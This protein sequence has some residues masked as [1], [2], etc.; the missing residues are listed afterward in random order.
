MTHNLL[1]DP[2]ISVSAGGGNQKLSLPGLLG[3]MARLEVTGFPAMRPHQGAAWHMFLVQLGALALWNEDQRAAP[4]EEGEWELLLR[5]LTAE[6][7]NDEPWRLIVDVP[8]RPAFLQPPR[9]D[10]LK[11]E[12]VS[13]PDGLDML[14]TS[15]NWD[16]KR[17]IARQNKPE[18]WL[19][20]LV[21][22]QTMEG[23]MGR[24]N[25][26]IARMNGGAA[27]RMLLGLAP[28]SACDMTVSPSAW[29][30][31]DVNCLLSEPREPHAGTLGGPA[32]LWSLPWEE[33][34]QLQ[35]GD[36]DPWFIEACRRVRLVEVSRTISAQ[37]SNSKK[38]RLD[39][40][41]LQ[42]NVGDPWAPVEKDDGKSFTLGASGFTYRQVYSLLYSG[43]W[44]VPVLAKH[45]PAET[46]DMVLVAQ[47]FVRGQGKTEGWHERRIAVPKPAFFASASAARIAAAQLGKL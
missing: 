34:E 43:D 38:A 20:A 15:R 46:G 10:N 4:E 13:T 6:F 33:G 26:G 19:F 32:L 29:W 41:A 44:K 9:P 7:V 22:L 35:V 17:A 45:G 28:G 36:L 18:D 21:S 40:K 42:G 47:A 31:R 11:W 30:C 5:N 14:V 27:S 3:A 8:S 12:P 24:G 25:Y 37:R 39:A 1:T 16:I 2:I 23:F